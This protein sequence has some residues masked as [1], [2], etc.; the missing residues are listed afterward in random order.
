MIRQM[1]P[2]RKRFFESL[3]SYAIGLAVIDWL[4]VDS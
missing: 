4:D 1:Q 2:I 3:Q